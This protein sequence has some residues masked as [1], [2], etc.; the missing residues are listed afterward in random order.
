MLKE[1]ITYFDFDGNERTESFYFNLTKAECME[2][3]LSTSGGL[4]KYIQ[5]IIEAEDKAQIVDTFKKIILKAY[6]EK[7]ADGKHFFKSP[8]IS[9]AFASTEAYSDLF[10][11]LASSAEEATRFVN[12]IIPQVPEDAKK[13]SDLKKAMI[14]GM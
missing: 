9:N 6:G 11:R 12:G 7:S 1:T 3:E 13:A 2:M 14:P 8:E 5:R 4:E 10:M